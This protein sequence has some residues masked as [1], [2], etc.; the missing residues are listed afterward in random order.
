MQKEQQIKEATAKFFKL[1][2]S[3]KS[4]L[5]KLII[6][7]EEIFSLFEKKEY[8][9]IPTLEI[10]NQQLYIEA[11]RKV[12]V[13]DE[14]LNL[15]YWLL[16]ISKID[17]DSNITIADTMKQ[18][19]QRKRTVEHSDTEGLVVDTRILFDLFRQIIVV[20]NQ[21]GTVNNTELKK[22]FCKLIDVRGLIF[23]I[24]M[25][26]EAYDRIDKLDQINQLTY[27]VASVNNFKNYRDENRGEYG[28]LKLMEKFHGRELLL[29]MKLNDTSKTSII[30]KFRN[31]FS[32]DS[33]EVKSAK[34]DGINDGIEDNIDLIRNKLKY[35]GLIT[36]NSELDDESIYKFLEQA[37]ENKY[38]YLKNIFEI[39]KFETM[40]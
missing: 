27:R 36:Y 19:N 33:L 23:E 12:E 14:D 2:S 15:F 25:N 35:S 26:Q 40:S 13:V 31:L 8:R 4:N 28:D 6:K 20:Y 29:T 5:K 10:D 30:E 22:F 18:V 7:I 11:M 34:V 39:E 1:N 37:F 3:N 38:L 17:P 24:I 9:K 32:D 21:R 16:T